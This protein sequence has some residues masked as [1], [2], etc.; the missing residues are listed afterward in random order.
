MLEGFA[1]L[2]AAFQERIAAG[3]H[4]GAAELFVEEGLGKGLWSE[5]PPDFRKMCTEN[6]ANTLDDLNDPESTAFDLEW[7]KDFTG[8]A[9]LTLGDQTAPLFPPVI[10]RLAEAMRSAEVQEF[11]GA[12]HPI[13]VEQ[14][15]DFAEAITAFVR[16]HTKG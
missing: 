15:E 8:P 10:T 13:M 14:P 4:A 1:Q 16:R 5:F 2:V 6:A 12:G 3:D 9:L 11:T 7:I